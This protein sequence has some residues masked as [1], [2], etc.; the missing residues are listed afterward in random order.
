MNP[1]FSVIVSSYNYRDFVLA[2]ID[3]ALA[4]NRAP[5]QIIVVDDGS[6]DGSPEHVSS[7]FGGDSRV[8]LILKANGGQLSAFVAGVAAAT[9][10][11]VCF[12][13]ADDLWEPDYLDHLHHAYT[14]PSA[15]D[16]VHTNLRLFG[17]RDEL[18]DNG[19]ADRDCGLTVLPSYHLQYWQGSPSSALSMR[20]GLAQRVLGLAEPLLQDWRVRADDVLVYGAHIFAAR[21]R[22]LAAAAVRY[23][24]HGNNLWVDRTSSRADTI[25]YEYR[26]DRMLAHYAQA[27]GVGPESLR[28][29]RREFETKPHPTRAEFRLYRRLAWSAPLPLGKR[30]ELVIAMLRHYR[31]TR[32]AAP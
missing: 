31:R 3:S 10:D 18:W 22:Y 28:R 30:L 2:A 7:R 6:T 20:R 15:P 24:V 26:L 13:D 23:R 16:F 17:N 4:Q 9:G 25:G 14:H 32:A 21:T 1:R 29:V 27:A 5:S 8:T 19:T 11:V 12:L